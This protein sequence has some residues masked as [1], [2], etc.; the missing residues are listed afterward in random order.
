[1][2][3][4][5]AWHRAAA[6]IVL[7]VAGGCGALGGTDRAAS[8]TRGV[9]MSLDIRKPD[10]QI[11]ELFRVTDAGRMEYGGGMRA[12]NGSTSWS[13]ELSRAEIDEFLSLLAASGWCDS[14]PEDDDASS[15]RCRIEVVCEGGR[16][17]FTVRGEPES[18]VRMR[19]FLDPIARRRLDPE[20]DRL[21]EA[22]ERREMTRGMERAGGSGAQTPA[23]TEDGSGAPPGSAGSSE[24]P[25]STPAGKP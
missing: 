21:P 24:G 8:P 18:V 12:F 20:L 3:S 4:P 10:Q 15:I 9:S 14:R 1:M 17:S 2:L 22:S 11:Y 13:T 16:H 23:A 7:I 5:R 25:S 19:A 6:V